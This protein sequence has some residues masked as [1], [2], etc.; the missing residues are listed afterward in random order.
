VL[1]SRASALVG[2]ETELAEVGRLL[3]APTEPSSPRGPRGV[4]PP[5]SPRGAAIFGEPGVGKTRIVA[6]A[7]AW[8]EAQGT[9]VEWVR[10][11]EA[12]RQIPLGSF[13]HLLAPGDEAHQR[14]DLLYQALARL[15]A[16]AEAAGG[17]LLLAVDDAHLLD[18]VSVALLHLVA[19]Q[20]PAQVLISVRTGEVVPP[21]LGTL[22]KDE[23]LGRLDV[24][25]LSQDATEAL[26]LDV[27]GRDVPA[28]SLDRIWRLSRGNALFV[29]ELLTAAMERQVNGAGGAIVLPAEGH[30]E[31]LRELVE[32]RLRLLEPSRRD[33][34]EAVAV[35]EQVPLAAAERLGVPEDLEALEARGLVQVV[36]T[37]AGAI[38][39]VAHPLYGEV[40]AGGLK[41]LRRRAVL[42]ALVAAVADVPDVDR[43]RL[44]TWRLDSGQPGDPAELLGLARE[45]L[46]RLDHRL[47]GRLA[48][49]AGGTERADAGLVLAEALSGQSRI[50]E[51]Q[52]VLE[53]LDASDPEHVARIAMARASDLFLQLDRSADA[54][55]VLEAAVDALDGEP[56]WQAEC[57]SVLAQMFMFA[58][59]LPEAGA[60]A[61]ELLADPG[62]PG[63]ARVRAASVAVTARGARGRTDDALGLLDPALHATARQHRR[64]VPYGDIQLRMARFQTLYWAGRVRELD[65][66][67]ADGMGLGTDHAPPSLRGIVAGFRGGALQLRGR[68]RAAFAEGQRSSRALAEADWFGQRPLAEAMRAR[69]A[70]FA[71][72]LDVADEAIHAADLAFAADPVR[73]ARTL[74]YIE[75]SRRWLLAARGSLA[76]AAQGCVDLGT[77]LEH[78]AKPLAVEVLHAAAR[79][80]RAADAADALERL[81]QDV[82]GPLAGPIARHAR[83]LAT[84]DAAALTLVAG[85]FEELGADLLAAEAHRSAA[86]AYRKGGN[87]APAAT[88][89]ARVEALLEA[90]GH[91][92]SPG[93][94]P[95]VPI[96][97]GLTQR[98]REVAS[99]A[100]AGRTSPEIAEAL[101][102]SVRTV[103]THLH[104]VYRKL[105]I[106]GRHQLAEAMGQ[107]VGGPA[108]PGAGPAGRAT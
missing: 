62:L 8:C 74:P 42:R 57:R 108:G 79:L 60:I 72:E 54:I 94:A 56:A 84:G 32:E 73:G 44:A 102:L 37:E 76:E 19:T 98:E 34:L 95:M 91:P 18:D 27:L 2:R 50:E 96:G 20:S 13:A 5:R 38:V 105:L 82:D 69:A 9:A 6:E 43:L 81:A 89:A 64:E 25:P 61:D 77:M 93:L 53:G 97:E 63:A 52:Q 103:D 23:L 7:V 92:R 33:V 48:L 83:A 66:F 31:R 59:R 10:A 86:N 104:R 45:A 40:L 17:R 106:D 46:G 101:F 99:L 11:T 78:M 71:G 26:V 55:N 14:D 22:W 3:A 24:G 1:G 47:A 87:G 49:A 65:A 80:G 30:Q 75:L 12:A 41:H 67:T 28:S 88:A 58:L 16:R 51:A 70:V 107:G 39:Q 90:C 35:A 21:G 15:D 85:E 29:R 68:M 4:R 100:A 36:E